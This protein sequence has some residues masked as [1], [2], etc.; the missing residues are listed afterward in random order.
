VA[1][2]PLGAERTSQIVKDN[3][4]IIVKW[5]SGSIV[6]AIREVSI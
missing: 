2:Q 4:D 6:D 3:A 1:I 5:N